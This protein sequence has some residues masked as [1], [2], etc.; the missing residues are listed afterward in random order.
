MQ[1]LLFFLA[2]VTGLMLVVRYIILPVLL[3]SQL[4]GSLSVLQLNGLAVK[5]AVLMAFLVLANEAC[6]QETDTTKKDLRISEIITTD[7]VDLPPPAEPEAEDGVYE[8]EDNK[9]KSVNKYFYKTLFGDSV[10]HPFEQRKTGAQV[11][12]SFSKQADFW[13]MNYQ[14]K[15]KK[16]SGKTGLGS[17][18]WLGPF[19]WIIIIGGFL[20]FI[21][22]W[23]VNNGQGSLL[24]RNPKTFATDEELQDIPEDIFAINYASAL[25]KAIANGDYRLGV[26][27]MYLQLLAN[28]HQRHIIKYKQ[29]STN[30][31]YLM[32]LHQTS[33]YAGFFKV[34]RH[35][36][37]AWY[38]L[39][40]VSKQAFDV[41]K[42][43]VEALTQKIS[44]R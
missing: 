13:Y 35:Y 26:R 12:D 43:E 8:D 21:I 41:I 16:S 2:G 39:F 19:L 18:N 42:Q 17:I 37:Y 31:D 33:Y 23:Y 5:C 10:D 28:M 14:P 6:A 15:E 30:F 1:Y 7:Q 27:L 44:Y 38:G 3:V 20:F 4:A 40:P 32:Q 36:E 11:K 29:E 22:W 25:S 34:T 24:R 9:Y